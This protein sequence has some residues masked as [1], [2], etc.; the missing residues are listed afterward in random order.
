MRYAVRTPERADKDPAL[1]R[2][3]SELRGDYRSDARWVLD[4]LT[5]NGGDADILTG[6]SLYQTL[7]AS[8]ACCQGSAGRHGTEL[9]T[10]DR[11]CRRR[12]HRA[13]SRRIVRVVQLAPPA[14]S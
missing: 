11:G 14:D 10:A 12:R 1:R 2:T 3:L 5:R 9:V 6:W 7:L 4:W 13:R 8:T